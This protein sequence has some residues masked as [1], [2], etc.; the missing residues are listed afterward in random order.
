[1]TVKVTLLNDTRTEDLET[2]LI[3]LEEPTNGAGLGL[4]TSATVAIADDDGPSSE[5]R[6]FRISEDYI[7]G[8]V[9]S[10]ALQPDGRILVAGDLSRVGSH[11]RA[12]IARLEADGTLD[13]AFNPVPQQDIE[14]V[15]RVDSV[16]VRN[17]EILF[18]G[19]VGPG[20]WPDSEGMM[21]TSWSGAV[22]RSASPLSL[23]SD[24]FWM[25]GAIPYRTNQW[26]VFGTFS[27]GAM[28]SGLARLNDDLTVDPDFRPPTLGAGTTIAT[29]VESDGRLL[30]AR[31]GPKLY[32]VA[33]DGSS[34]EVVS[35]P[36]AVQRVWG[37]TSLQDGRFLAWGSFRTNTEGP[38][39][40]LIRCF[41]D[42]RLDPSF[43]PELE[44]FTPT[45]SAAP[46]VASQLT[47]DRDGRILMVLHGSPV[48]HLGRPQD[49]LIRLLPDGAFDRSFEPVTFS[50]EGTDNSPVY[51]LIL[52][53]DGAILV[54]GEFN[55]VN[56]LRR[57]PLVRLKGTGVASGRIPAVRSI[58][59]SPT[60]VWDLRV[61]AA[62]A[63]TFTVER[64]TDLQH[65]HRVATNRFGF[66]QSIWQDG[67]TDSGDRSLFYRVVQNE[68]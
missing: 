19:E 31:T 27:S 25:G 33:S 37:L 52:Q 29:A 35:L 30:V 58:S 62:P 38:W 54:G 2:V 48:G 26:I 43:H 66:I 34:A 64:S 49:Y 56:G 23:D 41:P 5:D 59:R 3:S 17:S 24:S 7:R 63:Q 51:S 68:N 28:P 55:R 47:L 16:H 67:P 10:L 14:R 13:D 46:M 4:V 40:P 60:G 53:P 61:S 42:G 12:G 15:G 6:S 20:S 1:M 8:R 36:L 11:R 50:L 18:S 44:L 45:N 21:V 32:R 9:R 65:W 57:S 39:Q 22:L